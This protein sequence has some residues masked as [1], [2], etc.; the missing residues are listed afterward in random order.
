[1]EQDVEDFLA[2]YGVKGMRWGVRKKYDSV[3]RKGASPQKLTDEEKAVLKAVGDEP[4][5]SLMRRMKYGPDGEKRKLT[6]G[7]KDLLKAGA[8]VA[9]GVGAYLLLKEFG[10]RAMVDATVG[11]D[12]PTELKSFW[13]KYQKSGVPFDFDNLSTER[14]TLSPGSI[15][16]RISSA[17]ETE[18]RPG[19]FYAAFKPDDVTRYKAALPVYWKQWGVHNN[20]GGGYQ[21]GIKA[22]KGVKAPSQK[23]AFEIYVDMMKKAGAPIPKGNKARGMMFM[24]HAHGWVDKDNPITKNYFAHLKAWGFNGVLDFNDAGRLGEAPLRLLDSSEFEISKVSKLPL[25][26]IKQAQSVIT[27]VKHAIEEMMFS[28]SDD[29]EDFLAHYGV[30]GMKWGV[31]KDRPAGVSARTNREA[32]K[33]AQEFARAKMFYGQ[34]AGNRRKLIKATVEAKK[35]RDPSYAKA[36]DH[37]V[38]RQDFSTH[39]TKARKERKRTDRV[40]RTKKRAGYLARMTTGEMGTQAAFTAVAVGGAAYLNSPKGRATMAKRVTQVKNFAAKPGNKKRVNDISDFL[41]RNGL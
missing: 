1:M 34:G 16:T 18:I 36:F 37:H 2:H 13:K 14:I 35:K 21:V 19:G 39:A 10:E 24:G 32:R 12:A 9:V 29:V 41:K 6:E 33:D 40:D 8:K 4:G 17:K 22:L 11:K 26:S 3:G 23:E 38:E 5:D 27:K 20:D 28:M 25:S 30:K 7:Q 31:R 15:L